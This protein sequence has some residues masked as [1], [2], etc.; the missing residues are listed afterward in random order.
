VFISVLAQDDGAS[1]E[2]HVA[3]G[4][5]AGKDAKTMVA[6]LLLLPGFKKP[7]DLGL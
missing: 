5:R 3:S 2:L 1:V 6:A 4:R 7:L